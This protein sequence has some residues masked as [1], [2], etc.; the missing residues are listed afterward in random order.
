MKRLI[1]ILLVLVIYI[2]PSP[3]D[4]FLVSD[5]MDQDLP[6]QKLLHFELTI[7]DADIYQ[8]IP[9]FNTEG[10]ARLHFDL[11][12]FPDGEHHFDIV[13]VNLYN[14]KSVVVPFDLVIGIPQPPT[15]LQV[16]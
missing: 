15:G 11:K 6:Y 13:S 8:S 12:L 10:K 16:E 1:L 4:P 7:N 3:A 9:E 14:K 5:W 2:E